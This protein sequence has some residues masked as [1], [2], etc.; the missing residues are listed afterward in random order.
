MLSREEH[1]RYKAVKT[2]RGRSV[3]HVPSTLQLGSERF[4]SQER[5]KRLVAEAEEA[6]ALANVD[7][8]DTDL[9]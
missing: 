1:H 9:D 5:E 8:A 6:V 2:L 7:V 3:P 4:V